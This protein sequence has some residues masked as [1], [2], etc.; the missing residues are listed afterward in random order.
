LPRYLIVNADD[1]GTSVGVNRGIVEAH[2]R[3]IVTSSSVMVD[4]PAATDGVERAARAPELSLGLHFVGDDID[5]TDREVV[6]A[7]FDRQLERF[8]EL[9]GRGPT[10]IDSHHHVHRTEGAI[11]TFREVAAELGVP[12]REASN[13]AYVG[14]FY[15]RVGVEFLEQ[16]LRTEVVGEWTE[17]GCHPGY[18]DPDFVSAYRMEREEELRTLTD[19]RLPEVLAECGIE[20]RSYADFV[21]S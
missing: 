13:V 15:E 9:V 10:H 16:I 20:L 7:E 19:P 4:R 1:F 3:G 12:L 8:H 11:E 17:L 6:R 2:E 18:I 14:G 21:T 5:V